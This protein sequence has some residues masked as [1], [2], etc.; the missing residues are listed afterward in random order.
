MV[1]VIAVR[2]VDK[3]VDIIHVNIVEIVEEGNQRVGAPSIGRGDVVEMIQW[4][5]S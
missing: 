1:I 5:K 2:V 4:M 3:K